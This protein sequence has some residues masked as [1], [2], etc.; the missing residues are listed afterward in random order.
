MADVVM[1]GRL[2][3]VDIWS[4][5]VWIIGRCRPGARAFQDCEALVATNTFEVHQ[6]S[7]EGGGGAAH[8]NEVKRH[9][10]VR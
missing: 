10:V 2:R 1:R 7:S 9:I 6:T 5:K 4:I 3:W 8:L